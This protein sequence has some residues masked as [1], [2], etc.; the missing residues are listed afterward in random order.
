MKVIVMI[1]GKFVVIC[2]DDKSNIE[3][4]C[5]QEGMNISQNLPNDGWHT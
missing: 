5:K 1:V 4:V 3:K 2:R